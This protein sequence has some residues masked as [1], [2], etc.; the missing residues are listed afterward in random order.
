MIVCDVHAAP[1]CA[2]HLLE[3]AFRTECQPDLAVGAG[4]QRQPGAG[5]RRE[6][7]HRPAVHQ[8]E[9]HQVVVEQGA[10][11]DRLPGR[12]PQPEQRVPGDRH[13]LEVAARGFAEDHQLDADGVAAGAGIAP[14]E[15][16]AG[17]RAEMA[18]HGRLGRREGLRD[19]RERDR[20]RLFRQDDRGC[21]MPGRACRYLSARRRNAPS[22]AGH[23]AA[24][25]A[26]G[27]R[28]PA[29]LAS[30]FVPACKTLFRIMKQAGHSFTPRSVLSLASRSGLRDARE[31]RS[32]LTP[33]PKIDARQWHKMRNI[34][35]AGVCCNASISAATR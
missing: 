23:Y 20:R 9:H 11:R 7:D 15:A 34:E 29:W 4:V 16:V 28:R 35:T 33:A 19:R 25:S 27:P 10:E 12:I 32:N 17:Q 21:A 24:R 18:V 3:Q 1:R 2:Q 14:H 5:P 26:R 13:D 31:Y 30:G 6:F 22:A 8:I